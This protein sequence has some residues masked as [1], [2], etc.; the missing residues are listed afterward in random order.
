[1]NRLA[2]RVIGS[3]FSRMSPSLREIAATLLERDY[4]AISYG[5]LASWGYR[6]STIVDVGAFRGKWSGTARRIFGAVPTLMI[7]A[8]EGLLPNLE[9][10][11]AAEDNLLVAHAL[12]GARDGQQVQFFEMGTGSSMFPE[13]SNAP[14]TSERQLTQ[15]LDLVV[16]RRLGPVTNCFMKI[17][18]QGAELEVLAGGR[19]VL[20]NCSLVQLELAM[21][22]YNEGAP[23][24]PEV[25]QWMAAHEWLP[26]E[27]SGFSR[28]R[29]RLVQ[30][31]MLFAPANSDLRPGSFHF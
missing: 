31:D 30:I 10:I 19:S 11:A 18:V 15:S 5:R 26:I 6:P 25:V 21:L 17:D 9:K 13:T 28:P 2:Q 12:L 23:L 27:V 14:R 7:E 20:S 29:D 4:E 22:E 1:M 8:Q 3:V 24:L 16:A